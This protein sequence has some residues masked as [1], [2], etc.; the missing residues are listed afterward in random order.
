MAAAAS[1]SLGVGELR[2]GA[3][4]QPQGRGDR[5][6]ARWQCRCRKHRLRSR[7]VSSASY[8]ERRQEYFFSPYAVFNGLMMAAEGARGETAAEIGKTLRFPEAVR[9]AGVDADII[10]WKVAMVRTGMASLNEQF[11][12]VNR[13]ASAETQQRIAALRSELQRTKERAEKAQGKAIW[14]LMEKSRKIASELNLLL[15]TINPY[16]VRV[17]N[18]LWGKQTYPFKPSYLNAIRGSDGAGNVFLVDFRKDFEGSRQQINSWVETQTHNRIRD[19]LAKDAIDAQV[20]VILTSAV[21]FKGRWAEEFDANSTKDDDF[22]L[23]S[24]QKVRVSMMHNYCWEFVRYAAVSSDG[25]TFETPKWMSEGKD[26]GPHEQQQYYPDERGF[27]ML[28]LPYKGDQISMVVILPQA[29]D[30]LSRVETML[31][32]A[33][34]QAWISKASQR[35][36]EVFLPKF[37]LELEYPMRESLKAMGI[38]RAFDGRPPPRGAQFEGMCESTDPMLMVHIDEVQHKAFLDVNEKE[39]EAAAAMFLPAAPAPAAPSKPFTPVFRADR[40]FLFLIRDKTTGCIL[41]IGRMI[42]P[43]S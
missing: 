22:T 8:G 14:D 4:N 43:K 36:V 32:S 41:F 23:A 28:E 26:E 12:A 29:I 25:T 10:P 30:G 1:S 11:S 20:R 21:Y 13:P 39:T 34:L 35:P 27:T 2:A 7:F 24:G 38:V 18:A 37:K 33:N 5:Q 3:A 17:A 6:T 9:N 15:S 42:N 16:E 31:T 40:P 19:L